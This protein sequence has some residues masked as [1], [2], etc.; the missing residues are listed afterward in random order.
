MD[1]QKKKELLTTAVRAALNA[2]KAINEVYK[3]TDFGVEQ[4]ADETPL[5]LADRK[6]HEVIKT[7]LEKTDIPILS[8]EGR[9][10]A[11]ADREDWSFFWLVDPLDGT[12]EFI[13]KNGEFTVNIA[14][15][16]EGNPI[17]GVVYAPYVEDLYFGEKDFGAYKV[18]NLK[19]KEGNFNDLNDLMKRG[20]N[21]P[22]S[23]H[24]EKLVVVASRSHLNEDTQAFIDQLKEQHGEVDFISKGSSLKI[25]MVAEGKADIYP[26]FAPTMEWD[27]AAGHGVAVS[28][29]FHVTEKDEKTPLK[30]NKENLKNPWFIVK[31]TGV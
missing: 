15:V 9:D 8:E 11:Y 16:Q 20:I 19:D 1:N 3:G 23:E 31:R 10:I 14:L 13:K 30:Y 6:A 22:T 26:R 21:L 28:A 12:K 5:T 2:G 17:L 25:C 7:Y 24:R 27:T 18:E 29:G 4:K